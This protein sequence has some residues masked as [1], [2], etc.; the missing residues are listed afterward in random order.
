[1]QGGV[2][3]HYASNW[4]V[5]IAWTGVNSATRKLASMLNSPGLFRGFRGYFSGATS[6]GVTRSSGARQAMSGNKSFGGMN[7]ST[8]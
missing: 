7:S 8:S 2:L 3:I 1:M 6:H 4:T 5:P